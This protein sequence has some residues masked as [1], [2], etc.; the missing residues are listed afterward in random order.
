MHSTSN[1]PPTE[2]SEIRSS[3]EAVQNTFNNISDH[4]ESHFD[5]Q[6]S[7][8]AFSFNMR[9]DIVV[10]L[11]RNESG[12]IVDFACGPGEITQE[13]LKTANFQH[14]ILMDISPAM[15]AKA[16]KRMEEIDERKR[17]NIDF[18]GGD[19]F[20]LLKEGKVKHS[21]TDYEKDKHENNLGRL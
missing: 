20:A 12:T 19:V 7:G 15:L 18:L 21:P 16:R 5:K 6:K 11:T 1:K 17:Q 10:N 14:A 9:R 2:H 8:T 13:V 3:T 4:Y